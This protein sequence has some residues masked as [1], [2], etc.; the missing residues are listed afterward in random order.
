MRMRVYW[1]VYFVLL[2]ML[3]LVKI[4]GRFA[5]NAWNAALVLLCV[6]SV[7][8][9][10]AG[11]LGFYRKRSVRAGGKRLCFS[12]SIALPAS[13]PELSLLLSEA[14]VELVPPLARLTR[15]TCIF[16]DVTIRIPEGCS[17]RTVCRSTLSSVA[18]PSGLIGLNDE[19]VL[20]IGDGLQTQ[21]EVRCFCSKVT[22]RD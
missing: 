19:R 20:I 4:L 5:F 22:L 11:G 16:S 21:M 9:L 10:I 14:A 6:Q 3:L 1:V 18:A 15:I 2:T 12:G 13:S 7:L 17:V 8:F